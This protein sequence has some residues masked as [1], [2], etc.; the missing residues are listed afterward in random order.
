MN[1][2]CKT[3]SRRIFLGFAC[4]DGCRLGVESNGA[5]TRSRTPDLLITSQLLYQLS[6]VGTGWC[7]FLN[8]DAKYSQIMGRVQYFFA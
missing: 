3:L 2:I 7:S 1:V 8:E 5:D 6:Y 4:D